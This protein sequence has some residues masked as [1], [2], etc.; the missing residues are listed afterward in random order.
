MQY[1]FGGLNK[2]ICKL[3]E[4][5]RYDEAHLLPLALDIFQHKVLPVETEYISIQRTK[6]REWNHHCSLGKMGGVQIRVEED[7]R[8]RLGQPHA[9]Y[10]RTWLGFG[11]HELRH[12]PAL[13]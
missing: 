10:D 8:L 11:L 5:E 13:H 3:D 7:Y 1:C 4:A 2:F 12:G 6:R 9:V